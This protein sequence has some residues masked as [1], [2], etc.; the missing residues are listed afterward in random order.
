MYT[1]Y[2]YSFINIFM[3]LCAA[4]F[5]YLII[6]WWNYLLEGFMIPKKKQRRSFSPLFCKRRNYL[7]TWF[8]FFLAKL[9]GRH[10]W[11]VSASWAILNQCWLGPPG[12]TYLAV[13]SV[14]PLGAT[15]TKRHRLSD[16]WNRSSASDFWKLGVQETVSTQL[17][18]SEGLC[19]HR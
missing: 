14:V 11:F 1:S 10:V 4:P 16:L 7:D 8:S 9:I 12:D 18:P 6:K 2:L 17:L 19:F 13:S 3:A 5:H 15:I